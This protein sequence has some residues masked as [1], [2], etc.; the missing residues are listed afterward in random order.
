MFWQ[1]DAMIDSDGAVVESEVKVGSKWGFLPPEETYSFAFVDSDAEQCAG[2]ALPELTLGDGFMTDAAGLG[3]FHNAFDTISLTG[4]NS[5][6]GKYLQLN[7]SDGSQVACCLVEIQEQKEQSGGL[8]SNDGYDSSD[9]GDHSRVGRKDR[10]SRKDRRG[11]KDRR[12]R[13]DRKNKRGGRKLESVEEL[14]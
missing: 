6:V 12:D 5:I 3:G 4:E 14:I 11:R 1:H 8:A 7:D 9:D 2:T 13:K 10:K